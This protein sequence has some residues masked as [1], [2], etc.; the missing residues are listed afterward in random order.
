MY[1]FWQDNDFYKDWKKNQCN[2]KKSNTNETKCGDYTNLELTK[3]FPETDE[4][5]YD[6]INGEECFGHQMDAL[7]HC[8]DNKIPFLRWNGMLYDWHQNRVDE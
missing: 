4:D 6:A 2:I 3:P 5:I 7:K 1:T 8:I